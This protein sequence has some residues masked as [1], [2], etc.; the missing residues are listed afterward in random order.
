M[1]LRWYNDGMNGRMP[2]IPREG[3]T[4]RTLPA[5]NRL[6]WKDYQTTSLD[7]AFKLLAKSHEEIM[8]I[9]RRHSDK[10]L[11]TK[12]K[13]KWTG[14]T[15]LGSYLV[16]TLSSHYDWGIKTLKPMIKKTGIK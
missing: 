6:V 14:T 5:M 9:V 15:S 4:W 11:F 8:N 1:M 3:Y 16:S 10:D 2:I 12:R 13:Y 7:K